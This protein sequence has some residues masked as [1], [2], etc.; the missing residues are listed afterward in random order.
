MR[1]DDPAYPGLT[2]DNLTYYWDDGV[3]DEI[4]DAA[5]CTRGQAKARYAWETGSDFREVRCLARYVVLH[6]RQ[7]VWDGPGR[8]ECADQLYWDARDADPDA[9]L[10]LADAFKRTPTVVPDDWRPHEGMACWSVCRKDH[11]RAV[12]VWMCET[13]GDGKIPDTPPVNTRVRER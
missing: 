11:P 5:R 1:P 8:D 9:A 12:K 13:V 2:A 10:T 4:R 7:D 3:E 6:T